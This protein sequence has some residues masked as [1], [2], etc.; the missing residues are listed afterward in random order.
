MNSS[1]IRVFI[2]AIEKTGWTFF[3]ANQKSWKQSPQCAVHSHTVTIFLLDFDETV[4]RSLFPENEDQIRWGK[5]LTI[6]SPYF[7]H[8]FTPIMHFQWE[9]PS[10]AVTRPV[11]R[12]WRLIAQTTLLVG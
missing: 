5:N 8:F 3:Q 2:Y 12:L 11:D 7:P 9:T 10:N 6:P 4:H 1:W